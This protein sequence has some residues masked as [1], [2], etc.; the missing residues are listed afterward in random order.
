MRNFIDGGIVSYFRSQD[1]GHIRTLYNEGRI[2]ESSPEE[3]KYAAVVTH[4]VHHHGA[5]AAATFNVVVDE[6][7][8]SYQK[9]HKSRRQV[10][11]RDVA[12]ATAVVESHEATEGAC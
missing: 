5:E 1:S 11:F 3:V 10:H 6:L 9:E 2:T 8:R 7:G 12:K 4:V